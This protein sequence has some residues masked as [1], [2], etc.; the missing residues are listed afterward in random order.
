MEV[1]DE[2]KNRRNDDKWHVGK[3]IPL[4]LLVMMGLQTMGGVWWAASFSATM[5][6]KLD[7]LSFQVAALTADKYTKTDAQKDGAL[8]EQKISEIKRQMEDMRNIYFRR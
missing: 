2:V 5:T 1:E 7:D 8:Y 3:E 4:A 6:T